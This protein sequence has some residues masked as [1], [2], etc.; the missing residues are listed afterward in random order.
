MW[1]NEVT[2]LVLFVSFLGLSCA[3]YIELDNVTDPNRSARVYRGNDAR[4]GQIFKSFGK[5]ISHL[6]STDGPIGYCGVSLIDSR[7]ILTA[8][9]CLLDPEPF[10]IEIILGFYNAADASSQ[11]KRLVQH[12]YV[13]E[14]FDP[15][16]LNND[17]AICVLHEQAT[18]TSTVQPI[19][20]SMI[21]EMPN[22][23]VQI[24]GTGR[25][26][27]VMNGQ[28]SVLKYTDLMTIP[29]AKCQRFFPRDSFPP[30]KICTQSSIGASVCK[31]DSG[32]ALMKT[33]YGIQIGVVSA[34]AKGGCE[35]G[36]PN[37]F[38]KIS[39]YF[40]WIRS[41]SSAT[42]SQY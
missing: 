10:K 14:E 2:V 29:N 24:A 35:V 34:S 39:S 38:T 16:T 25:T 1:V 40:D 27:E 32:S 15:I 41:R 21:Y 4:K 20:L 42:W 5:M 26:F 11:Q 8:A 12:C 3:E 33:V 37:I 6:P 7:H 22:T 13:H 17:I 36:L 23:P 31:G 9:H 18:F 28:S 30:S 19:Q